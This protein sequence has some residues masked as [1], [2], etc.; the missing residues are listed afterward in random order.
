M[1]WFI[2]LLTLSGYNF[3]FWIFIGIIRFFQEKFFIKRKDYRF[4]PNPITLKDVAAIIPAHNE[5]TSIE[6]TITALLKVLPKKNIYVA[7]D[8]S[9]D[10]TVDVVRKMGIRSL[11]IK[12]NKGKARALVYTMNEYGLLKAYKAILI[13]DADTTIDQHYMN[14]ALPYFRDKDIAAVAPYEYTRW[15]KYNFKEL[16]FILYRVRLW[17]IIQWGMRFG[18]TWKYTNATYIIPGSLCLYRTS[19]LEKL[20]IDAPGLII[21][22][23]NMTFE[24]HKKRL[25]K[26]ASHPSIHG[27]SQDPTNFTDY[28]KQIKRWNI[29]FWQ[30]VKRNGIWPS[31]FWLSTGIFLLELL[32]Y[33]VLIALL[34]VIVFY[35]F[36]NNFAPITIPFIASRLTLWDMVFGIY[37]VDYITT[38]IAAFIERKPLMLLYGLLFIFIRYIDA[39][40]YLY[41]IPKAFLSTYSGQWTSPKR[42]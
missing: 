38:I 28:V 13:N 10:K 18:Q 1:V 33:T 24:V 41:A 5:E 32:S 27:I 20:D 7:S 22:D 16:Y 34:P 37:I 40:I 9:T 11:D 29:G 23:F 6:R 15:R 36:I 35:F 25:G 30:T 12:P 2:G 17:R 14:R 3:S 21:E 26:I 4:V 42:S 39:L 31:F 8:N 19:V